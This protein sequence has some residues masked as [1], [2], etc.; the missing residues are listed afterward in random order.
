MFFALGITVLLG[1]RALKSGADRLLIFATMALT[2]VLDLIVFNK[3]GSPQFMAWLAIP[4]IALIIFKAQKLRLLTTGLMLI[5]ATT[6]LVYPV[7][8][9]DL[10]GLGDLSVIL[11]T[12]RNALL[13]AMLVYANVR[14]GAL[15]KK[16]RI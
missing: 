8:Y 12:I 4:M 14:L 9:M 13:I 7:F 1:Y 5:A 11:L 3:V 15:S 6:N 2:A 10:M 16:L